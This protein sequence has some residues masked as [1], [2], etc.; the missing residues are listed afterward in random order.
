MILQLY[1]ACPENMQEAEVLRKDLYAPPQNREELEKLRKELEEMKRSTCGVCRKK[2][3][4]PQQ[5]MKCLCD[6]VFCP[7]HRTSEQHKCPV[8]F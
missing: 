4:I 5:S 6:G 2:L 1:F 3:P 8:S 7:K